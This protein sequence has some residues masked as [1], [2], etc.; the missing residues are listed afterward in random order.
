MSTA[1]PADRQQLH[2][3]RQ[4][5]THTKTIRQTYARRLRGAFG[6]INATIRE[7]VG[8]EDILGLRDTDLETDEV[9]QLLQTFADAAGGGDRA[10]EL[11]A[12]NDPGNLGEL[13]PGERIAA[14]EDWLDEAM[15]SEVLE[16]IDRDENVWVRRSYE[17]GVIDADTNLRRAGVDV[18]ATDA[19][20]ARQL[21]QMP[22]HE[23][24]LQ[25]LFARN[26]SELQGITDAV[27][28]QVTRELAEAIGSGLNPTETAR[29]ITDRVEKI[30]KTRATVLARTETINAHSQATI[31][32][33]RQQ[34]VEQV[35]VEPEI[36]VQTAGDQQVCEE[37]A[38]VAQ[39]GP[40]PLDEF[41]GSENQPPIH[42]QC[43]C[44]VL[45]VV[46]EAAAE[47]IARHP[48]AFIRL[49]RGA[50]FQQAGYYEALAVADIRQAAQL[51]A[52][53][54]GG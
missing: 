38:D 42:P 18:D 51:T 50:A 29:R 16:V 27:S 6:R 25:V 3:Q 2:A 40:W 52:H 12:V 53:A 26:F 24:K 14:F 54:V 34:G 39:R 35:G 9:E 1:P 11:R 43:R 23:R 7:S 13:P 37:C 32:R 36:Q 21:V 19:E 15:E 20:A 22:V 44:A 30:G 10:A 33:Y 47:A 41:E 8:S 31:E 17:R 45:P 4:D 48:D 49:Y 28:Q 5:P 46:N